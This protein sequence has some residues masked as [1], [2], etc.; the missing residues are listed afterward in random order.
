MITMFPK[1]NEG[2][3]LGAGQVCHQRAQ[4]GKDVLQSGGINSSA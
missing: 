2:K 3:G 4:H 1:G